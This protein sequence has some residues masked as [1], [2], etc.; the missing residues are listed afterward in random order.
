[1]MTYAAFTLFESSTGAF[2]SQCGW[3]KSWV[4]VSMDQN[5]LREKSDESEVLFRTEFC[6]SW[7]AVR[8]WSDPKLTWLQE[9][10]KNA[11]HTN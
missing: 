7:I 10:H 2:S 4:S 9:V 6:H 1:M 8:K 11:V 5:N 3:F